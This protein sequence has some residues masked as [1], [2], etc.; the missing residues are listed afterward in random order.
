MIA[1]AWSLNTQEGVLSQ[2]WKHSALHSETMF[3]NQPTNQSTIKT[4][5]EKTK[6]T[7]NNSK[8]SQN[9]KCKRKSKK[10]SSKF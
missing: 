10:V 2:A 1:Y 5:Q 8:E 7:N 4:N 6:Q 3:Q 9:K